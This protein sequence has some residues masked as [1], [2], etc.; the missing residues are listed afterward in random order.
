MSKLACLSE[1]AGPPLKGKANLLV[2]WGPL[3]ATDRRLGLDG[4]RRLFRWSRISISDFHSEV[5][6]LCDD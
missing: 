6:Q 1:L 3:L 5:S 2:L 4:R